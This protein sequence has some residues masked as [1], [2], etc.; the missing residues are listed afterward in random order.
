MSLK[1]LLRNGCIGAALVFACLISAGQD[2][3]WRCGSEYTNNPN[4]AEFKLKNCKLLEAPKQSRYN[5]QGSSQV[6][7]AVDHKTSKGCK[8][9]F[10]ELSS[11]SSSNRPMKKLDWSG[12]CVGGYAD[13][14][15][16]ANSVWANGGTGKTVATFRRGREEGY[17][18]EEIRFPGGASQRYIGNFTHGRNH[19]HG[20]ATWVN[21]QGITTANYKGEFQEGKPWGTGRFEYESKIVYEGKVRQG[22]FHGRG[23]LTTPS[24]VSIA[25]DFSNGQ[26]PTSGRIDYP[27]GSVYEGQLSDYRANG[28]GRQTYQ[29]GAVYAGDFKNGVADGQGVLTTNGSSVNV[30][31]DQGKFSRWYSATEVAEASRIEGQRRI[32]EQREQEAA[33]RAQRAQ[34]LAE[35]GAQ[36]QEQQRR[37]RESSKYLCMAAMMGRPTGFGTA[38]ESLANIAACN[39]DPY[40]NL[41]PS[42]RSGDAQTGCECKCVAGEVKA[43]CSSAI[44]LRP[45]CAPRVCPIVPPAL[46]PLPTQRL[47]PLGTRGCTQKQVYNERT[48]QYEWQEVCY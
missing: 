20:E 46:Q 23:T 48:F 31:A 37:D 8:I 14:D 43:L 15:G 29:N 1:T 21:A 40:A 24:G 2:R 32:D 44:D 30:K 6:W 22:N 33:L 7:I 47:P 19:G 4:A 28:Q 17:G 13:G 34:Q 45:V 39:S 5:D 10:Y 27:S 38:A 42:P 36:L 16:T 26:S 35:L 41:S 9:V 25:G 11:Q 12:R 3:I 18:T